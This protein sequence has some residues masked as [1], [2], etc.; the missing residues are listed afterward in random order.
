MPSNPKRW[1]SG[2]RNQPWL[3]HA[4]RTTIAATVALAIA[5]VVKLPEP[6]WAPITAIIVMQSTLGAVWN[7]SKQRLI[8]TVLGTAFGVLAAT[9]VDSQLIAFGAGI[10]VLGL[11]CA[12]LRL[13]QTAYRFAGITYA[14]IVLITRSEAVWLVGI[15][16]FAEVSLG[17][18]V[19]LAFSA[20]WPKRPLA[21]GRTTLS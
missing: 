4:V 7:V 18:A 5:M 21:A 3:I 16:R 13:D 10:F 12:L 1:L 14:I 11:I 15:H 17:I 9:F 8:G 2:V 19:A 20:L 6:Y